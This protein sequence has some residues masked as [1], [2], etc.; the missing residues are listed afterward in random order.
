MPAMENAIALVVGIANYQYINKLP[1]T[2]LK[3]LPVKIAPIDEIQLPV[4][5]SML[6][7]LNLTH[8]RRAGREFGRLVRAL[9][10]SL[11]RR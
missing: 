3:G 8:P 11:P 5:L 7:T 10:A 9:K 1:P 2:V 4:W 6:T